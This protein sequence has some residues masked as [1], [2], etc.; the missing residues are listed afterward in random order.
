MKNNE[1]NIPVLVV[2][3]GSQTTQLILRRIRELGVYCEIV[4]YKNL[5][6][7][8]KKYSPKALIFSGG[9]SSA[10]VNS[11]PKV[12]ED[13]YKLNIPI[14][15]ICYGMQIICQQLKG[16]VKETNTREFGKANIK[17]LKNSAI[18]GSSLKI[19]NKSQVW[20]SHGDQVEKLP[21]GFEILA[22]TKDNN[23][24]AISSK[25]KKI[26]GIQFHP[27]VIHTLKGRTII[28]NFVLKISKIKP[29]WKIKNYLDEKINQIKKQVK[30]DE[31]I[32]GLSGGVDS[33][34]VAALINKAVGRKLT[35]IFVNHG[36]LRKDEEKE[37]MNDFKKYTNAKINQ[38][39]VKYHR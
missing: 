19:G 34:V 38:K 27:E 39:L 16:K 12:S 3:F 32:C 9:P 17:I 11:S 24:S 13:I 29:N 7:E 20:M 1:K 31:V 26:F 33:S 35:C 30:N 2:D 37:V 18:F 6:F 22:Y 8:V 14:L 21:K 23:I 5:M 28:K 36:L 15:G 10:F 25:E 4:S